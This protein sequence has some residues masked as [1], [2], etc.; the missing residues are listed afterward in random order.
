[1]PLALL[2]IS[3]SALAQKKCELFQNEASFGFEKSALSGSLQDE[4]GGSKLDIKNDLGITHTTT[5]LKAMFN[6]STTHHKFGFKLEKFKHSGSKKLSSNIVYNGSQYATASLISSKISLK[7]AKAKY[8]YRFTEDFALGL[9][10]DALRF[11]TMLNDEE[12]KKTIVMPAIALEYMH[13][14]EE[15]FS[16]ITKASSTI[17]GNSKQHYGYAGLSY[18]LKMLG[19]SSLHIGY[20]YKKLNLHTDKIHA[21]LKYQGLYAGLA[22]KF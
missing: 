19:C 2:L 4:S 12:T 8:R 10:L 21:D 3:S 6:K 15:G 13:P 16:F 14:I 20:Q 22:M 17:S 1:M 7:W 5:G 11:K 18:D 9:D